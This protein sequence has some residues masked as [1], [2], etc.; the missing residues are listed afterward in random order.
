[1]NLSSEV[2]QINLSKSEKV[3]LEH[4]LNANSLKSLSKDSKI[5]ELARVQRI[6]LVDVQKKDQLKH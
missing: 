4:I 3:S 5:D 6:H 1:M 2:K